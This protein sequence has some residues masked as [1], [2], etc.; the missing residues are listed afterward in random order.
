[1]VPYLSH[2]FL[3]NKPLMHLKNVN[4]HSQHCDRAVLEGVCRCVG[5]GWQRGGDGTLLM[6]LLLLLFLQ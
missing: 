4:N 5:L 3:Q 2:K 1:M 6:E